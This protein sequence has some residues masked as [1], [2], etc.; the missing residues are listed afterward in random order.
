V[1][2]EDFKFVIDRVRSQFSKTELVDSL[3]DF[4]RQNN[5][6]S[7]ATRDYDIWPKRIATS[8][9]F[10]RYFGTWGKALQAAGLRTSRGHKLDPKEMVA[11]FQACW[12]EIRSVP[13]QRQLEAFLERGN[14]PFRYKSYLKHFGGLGALA[15][16][17]VQV[18]SGELAPSQLYSPQSKKRISARAIPLSVR[19]AVL[20]R[21]DYRCVKCGATPKSDPTV[22]LNVDHIIAV[23]RGGSGD[24]SNLQ[25]LCFECNQGK[26]DG[27]N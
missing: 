1:S 17:V 10:C 7:V 24:I 13:S 8:D 20:K 27:D 21:D 25:T 4:A 6:S 11:A 12:K 22:M 16:R 2:T 3:R 9:T 23:A 26:K 18:Q 14:Y 5:V 15:R 19:H